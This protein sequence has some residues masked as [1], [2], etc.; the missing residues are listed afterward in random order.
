MAELLKKRPAGS[1]DPDKLLE[2][3]RALQSHLGELN[4][5]WSA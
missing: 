2:L 5:M 3:Q 1:P 4:Q